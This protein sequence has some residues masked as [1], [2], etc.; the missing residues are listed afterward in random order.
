MISKVP[1]FLE[2]ANLL[3]K[4]KFKFHISAELGASH[5]IV[6][7]DDSDPDSRFTAGGGEEPT[8]AAA[9]VY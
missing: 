2:K 7:G 9:L 3:G 8:V 1:A 4:K 5:G 6:T